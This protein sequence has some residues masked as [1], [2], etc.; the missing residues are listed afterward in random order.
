M[1]AASPVYPRDFLRSHEGAPALPGL[2]FKAAHFMA[3]FNGKQLFEVN[4][5]TS[6]DAGKVGSGPRTP[7]TLFDRVTCGETK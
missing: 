1:I 6:T 4:D 7:V 3:P 2:D 5:S